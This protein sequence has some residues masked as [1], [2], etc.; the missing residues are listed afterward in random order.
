MKERDLPHNIECEQA[1]LGALLLD[2][3]VY[4]DVEGRLH[5]DHFFDPLHGR[6]FE[7]LEKLIRRGKLA[8]AVVLKTEFEHD[9]AMLDIGGAVYLADLMR[10]APEPSSAHE[11]GS[12]VTELYLQRALIR[13]C[14]TVSAMT[15]N[16]DADMT[17]VELLNKAEQE[18][19]RISDESQTGQVELSDPDAGVNAVWDRTRVAQQRGQA[20]GIETG[21]RGI[22]KILGPLP[23]STYAVLAGRPSMGKTAVAIDWARGVAQQGG[24]VGFFSVADMS[25]ERLWQRMMVSAA[26]R[27]GAIIST[28]DFKTGKFFSEADADMVHAASEELKASLRGRFLMSDKRGMTVAEIKR[29]AREMKRRM[30]GLDLIVVDYLQRVGEDRKRKDNNR[31]QAVADIS[32]ALQQMAADLGCVLLATAQISRG[33]EQRDD[34]RPKMSDLKESGAIEEDADIVILAYRPEYYLERERPAEGSKN[35]DTWQRDYNLSRDRLDLIV[36]KNRD[37]QAGT[38]HMVFKTDSVRVEDE[39]PDDF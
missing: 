12:V 34:K 8:D 18:F 36:G 35:F 31:A 27:K 20:E 13:A 1:I 7:A 21:Y 29:A 14:Q 30:G 28:R 24:K 2:N 19:A 5:A 11:Y 33:V 22:D 9:P 26:A 6:V 32:G 4:F 10:D 3:G 23:P 37:D 39:A 15:L 16:A 17:A 25:R 38:A